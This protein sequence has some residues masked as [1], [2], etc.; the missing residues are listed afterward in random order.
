MSTSRIVTTTSN[1]SS[2]AGPSRSRPVPPLPADPSVS[3]EED[4][5]DEDEDE[6]IRR[7][8]ARVERVRVRKAAEAARKA[9]EE[10]AARAAAARER[11]AQEAQE[12][13]LRAQQQEAEVA[14][15]CRL[16]ADA[17]AA[18]SQRGTSPSEMSVSPRRPV[19]EIRREKGKGR[20]KVPAQPVGGDPDDGDDDDEEKEPCERCKAKKIPCLQ[21]AG[22]W[23][24]V[25]CKP[26]HDSKVRCSYSGRPSTGKREGGSGERMAIMESQM[27]QSLADLRALQ[28]AN[29]KSHQY[30]RQLL[31]QQ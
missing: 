30:L 8:Q 19:V 13:A 10:K 3:E 23:S 18:R 29:S 20:A 22:K 24:S 28:E 5:E 4:L 21:Q 1:K 15:R 7:A 17:A 9:T 6:I 25:I 26:C 14:E 2:T 31:R 16:L 12:R 27:A 11:A